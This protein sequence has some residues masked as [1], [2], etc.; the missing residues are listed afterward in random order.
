M[1]RIFSDPTGTP[2]E[3]KSVRN[4]AGTCLD[5]GEVVI[6]SQAG[7]S[8]FP[9]TNNNFGS[10]P[11][12]STADSEVDNVGYDSSFSSLDGQAQSSYA[13]MWGRLAAGHQLSVLVDDCYCVGE[14]DD[15]AGLSIGRP[16]F[17]NVRTLP[18]FWVP[19]RSS[20]G[21]VGG[22]SVELD[23]VTNAEYSQGTGRFTLTKR[24]ITVLVDGGDVV[25]IPPDVFQA[26]VC[27]SS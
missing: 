11:T 8:S 14:G 3:G 22:E 13:D 10:L 24:K 1:K 5:T 20:G 15:F 7:C 26:V 18:F 4:L 12:A 9:V 25:P 21:G 6:I 23:V 19:V 17:P 16:R 27:P 2:G